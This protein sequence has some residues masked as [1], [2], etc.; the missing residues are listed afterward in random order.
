MKRLCILLLVITAVFLLTSCGPIQPPR[1]DLYLY[2]PTTA[3]STFPEYD[4]Y[5]DTSPL[6]D[7]DVADLDSGIGTTTQLRDRIFE[8]VETDYYE[9]D[10]DVS[11]STDVPPLFVP[12]S[13]LVQAAEIG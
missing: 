10:V 13:M 1:N 2:F 12:L 9:F 3:D 5:L 11:M 8:I 6:A 7:F 4:D